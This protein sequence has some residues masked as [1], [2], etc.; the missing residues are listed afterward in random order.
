[1]KL[2]LLAPENSPSWGGVG[3]YTYNLIKY[4][5]KDVE[6]HVITVD[7]DINDSYERILKNENVHIH[8]I[9]KVSA[10]DSFFYNL[11]FQ[12]DLF[13]KIKKLNK[14]YNFDLI[15]SHSGHLPHY[16]SQYW[17]I[18]PM[19]T[20]VHTETKGWKEARNLIKY[21]KDKIE[22]LSDFFT[23]FIAFGEKKTFENSDRL[24]PI[25][26]FTLNQI[27]NAY[28]VDTGSRAQVIHNGV[29]VEL[30]KPF[31]I[32]KD[33]KIT[34]SFLGRFIS[35]KGAEIFLEAI[36]QINNN[37]YDIKVL[38]GGR[39][40]AEYLK[41]VVPSLNDKI[42]YF[43]RIPYPDMP[44]IYNMSDIVVL[45]SLYEGCSGTVLEA[46]A[47]EKLVIA[48][49]VGGTPEIIKD[50]QNGLLFQPRNSIDLKNKIISVLEETNAID[51]LQRNGRKTIINDFDWKIKAKE[52]HSQYLSLTN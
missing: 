8:K 4:L 31:E 43:G 38:L 23:P 16:F 51:H 27:N 35:I 40:S 5:P 2:A 45:P 30:F 7:R 34:I 33:K 19:I 39:A 50:N 20:T 17:K 1:M 46:M 32:E 11:R 41:R 29:D 42:S 47:C 24:L 44:G 37:G 13:R 10:G 49:E 15:H 6:I 28:D 9:T 25:S 12:I 52:I 21:N 22:I 14:L 26:Q 36:K 3:S 18:A 48:S